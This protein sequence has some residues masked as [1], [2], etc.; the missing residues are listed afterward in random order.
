M[1]EMTPFQYAGFWD[2]PRY[3]VLSYR[4]RCLLLR[5]EFD[6]A[7]DEYELNYTVFVL[8]ESAKSAV[9]DGNWDFYNKTPMAEIGQ[10]PVHDVVFDPSKREELDASCLDNLFAG[11]R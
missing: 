2:V 6:E 1:A 11:Q 3:I 5:S 4:G 10:V 8:P 9:Q 7:L